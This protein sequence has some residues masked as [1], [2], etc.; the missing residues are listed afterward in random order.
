MMRWLDELLHPAKKC[1]RLGHAMRDRE[2]WVYLWP[3][4]SLFNSVATEAVEITPTCVRCGHT[5]ET[6]LEI[7]RHLTGLTM[8]SSDWRILRRD[9]RLPR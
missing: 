7:E 2:Q 1:A 3:S 6:R 8:P 9:G 5:E 4:R